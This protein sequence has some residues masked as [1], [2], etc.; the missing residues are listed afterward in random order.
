VT[1][2]TAGAVSGAGFVVI[3][4]GPAGQKAAIQAAKAGHDV[5][6]VEREGAV[7]GACVRTGTIPSKTLRE[8]ATRPRLHGEPEAVERPM[9]ELLA[10]VADV[11]DAHD[12]YMTAQLE[13]NGVRVLRGQARFLG[14]TR[15]EVL[16]LSG[17]P[18]QLEAPR[19]VIATGSRPRAPAQLAI[20]HEHVLDSDSIL[21]LSWLPRSLL[22]LGGG[23]IACEY[24]SIFA[25]LGCRV[26]Q[27]DRHHRPLSFVD[28]ELTDVYVEALRAAGGDFLPGVGVR[29][30]HWDGISQV[31]AEFEDGRRVAADK[32]LVALGRIANV[33]E[34][35]L[36]AAGVALTTAGHIE[37]DAMLQTT[38]PGIYA[39]GDV[40]GPPAL[41]SAAMEQ[42]RRA[43]CHALGLTTPPGFTAP[44]PAGIYAIPEMS[45]VG[46]DEAAARQRHGGALVGRARFEEIARGQISGRQRGLLKM[47]ATPD[48]RQVVGVQ[49]VGDGATEL[50]AV[51]QVG[52]MA[53][54]EVDAY[55]DAVFN[56][57]TMTEA[58]RVAALDIVRQRRRAGGPLDLGAASAA[59]ARSA[60][61]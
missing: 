31:R 15:L 25:S 2:T 4:S 7:G 59:R 12:R 47:V 58:Y 9:E 36:A 41:A 33:E 30:L 20:D 38:A 32:A 16:R 35:D 23:V 57:P 43:A 17:P 61:G 51:G 45:T 40:I 11:V 60:A 48:G 54:L 6:L 24:A 26:A 21:S 27:V 10:G 53:A 18:L 56:F 37:V 5:V 19:M 39:A 28:A 34:L 1:R 8:R 50:V 29:A 13:R 52:L 22:V 46:L 44:L 49:V 3:G 14:P 55:V 42:G